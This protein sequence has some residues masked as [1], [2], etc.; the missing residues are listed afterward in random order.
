ML[1]AYC[2]F[3]LGIATLASH[4]YLT[5]PLTTSSVANPAVRLTPRYDPD[6]ESLGPPYDL[7]TVSNGH[8]DDGIHGATAP[9]QIPES[10]AAAGIAVT[11]GD[12][13]QPNSI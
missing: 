1:L 10:A 11:S 5:S 3:L 6:A 12:V 9:T 7:H 8:H 13:F 2:Q 4:L